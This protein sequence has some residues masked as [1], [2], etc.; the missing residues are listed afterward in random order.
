MFAILNAM[1]PR[2]VRLVEFVEDGLVPEGDGPAPGGQRGLV[3][4]QHLREHR[5]D[6]VC[7]L[8]KMLLLYVPP[9]VRLSDL[10]HHGDHDLRLVEAADGHVQRRHQVDDVRLELRVRDVLLFWNVPDH[11]EELLGVWIRSE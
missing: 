7:Q 10:V 2:V 1:L 5:H 11:S 6:H 3:Q 9:V 8:I 4:V